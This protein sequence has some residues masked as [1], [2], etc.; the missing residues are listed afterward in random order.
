MGFTIM[1]ASRALNE[2]HDAGLLHFELTG[3]TGRSKEYRRID[4]PDY[5]QRGKMYLSSPVIKEIYLSELPKGLLVA[6]LEALSSLS[7][8]NPPESPV[9]AI[10]REEYISKK[11]TLQIINN[12]DRIN[13]ERLPLLQIWSYDPR[14]F[15]TDS[16]VDRMSLYASLIKE[17]ENDERTAQA[18]S[19]ALQKETWYTD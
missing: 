5:F 15:S 1:T 14:K 17:N 2:L 19:E 13:D 10:G 18:L 7:M 11:S 3:K 4:D 16:L 8:L 9:R 6:G 12:Q